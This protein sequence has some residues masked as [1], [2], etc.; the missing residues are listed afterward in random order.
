MKVAP[1]VTERTVKLS[2]LLASRFFGFIGV[3]LRDGSLRAFLQAT[4]VSA[5]VRLWWCAISTALERFG[6]ELGREEATA[7]LSDVLPIHSIL[8]EGERVAVPTVLSPRLHPCNPVNRQRSLSSPGISR[9][10]AC[11]LV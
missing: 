11:S 2:I 4:A 9:G 8:R 3:V 6:A 10:F 7:S 5:Q 1:S